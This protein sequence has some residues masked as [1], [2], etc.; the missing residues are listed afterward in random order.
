M[1]IG[2]GDRADE[3]GDDRGDDDGAIT[4]STV[5]RRMEGNHDNGEGLRYG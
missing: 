3:R 2:T 4:V 1:S 5:R